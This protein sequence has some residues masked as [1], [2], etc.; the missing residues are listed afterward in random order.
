[1][2]FKNCLETVKIYHNLAM[3]P[4]RNH[5][6]AYVALWHIYIL[7]NITYIWIVFFIFNPA[8]HRLREMRSTLPTTTAT[9]IVRLG[10][11]GDVP[12]GRRRVKPFSSIVWVFVIITLVEVWVWSIVV[13]AVVVVVVA[14][15]VTAV[16]VI[17]IMSCIVIRRRRRCVVVL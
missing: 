17:I 13:V 1:M 15:V 8:P 7:S 16:V 4:K 14:V 11:R 12:I 9:V 2:P 10:R 5:L 6:S 3:V